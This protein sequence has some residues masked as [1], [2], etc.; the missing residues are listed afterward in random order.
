MPPL[1]VADDL[2]IQFSRD[3][4]RRQVPERFDV[5]V[6]LAQLGDFLDTP[7]RHL[8]SGMKAR[9]GFAVV[10]SLD[11]PI[12][13]VDQVLA[14]GDRAFREERCTR[15]AAM[16][17]RGRTFFL[18]SHTERD[19]QRFCTRAVYLRAGEVVPDGSSGDARAR[20]HADD[21]RERR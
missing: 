17:S 14:V 20:Y 6:D 4:R 1:F 15:M 2:G 9:V 10:T 5:G 11:E 12:V 18:V 19:L 3:R 8:S 7:F 13:L 21:G 16:L